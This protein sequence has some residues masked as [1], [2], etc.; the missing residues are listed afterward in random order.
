MQPDPQSITTARS[1]LVLVD[2]QERL[3]PVMS[4]ADSLLANT[5]LL[6]KAASILNI[7]VLVAEQY[8]R[9]LGH[10]VPAL[11]QEVSDCR[12]FEKLTFSACGT[13]GIPEALAAAGRPDV[14]LA[15]I[16][17]HV[18]VM[19]TCLG[20]LRQGF[21]VFVCADAIASRTPENCR[22]GL[23]RMRSAGAL[24][25]STEMVLFEWLE[26]AGSPEFKHIQAL[27]K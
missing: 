23:E 5:L 13:P 14:I 20:L 2:I 27:L 24:P 21:R 6:A 26:K 18:C 22:S 10:T 1:V 7:P 12:V 4:G 25:A 19:Q 9:G 15:G 8:P 11:K 3:L 16:E 17:S